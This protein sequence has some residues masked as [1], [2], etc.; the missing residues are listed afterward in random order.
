[1]LDMFEKLINEHGSSVILRERLELIFDKYSLLEEKLA[2]SEKRNSVIDAENKDLKLQ[3]NRAEIEMAHLRG[4]IDASKSQDVNKLDEA[5]ELILKKLYEV[6]RG[7]TINQ[8][9]ND[10]GIDEQL[11][12]YH[13]DILK[14]EKLID[15]GPLI[16]NQPITFKLSKNGRKYVIE[17]VDI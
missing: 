17:E 3:L 16:V 12:I 1:M 7:L 14:E 13:T 10:V 4:I 11:V 15:F 9:S 2:E 6:N 5:K 8:I